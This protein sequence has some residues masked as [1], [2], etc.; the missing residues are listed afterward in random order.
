[1]LS[2][3]VKNKI[4][5]PE[6]N[7]QDDLRYIASRVFIP[8]LQQYID[9]QI[10]VNES[11]LP[12]IEPKTIA[13]KLRKGLSPKILTATGKLRSSL[14]SFDRGKRTVVISIAGDRKEIGGYLQIEGIK[15]RLGRKYFNFFGISS[16]MEKDA[17]SYM[18]AKIQKALKNG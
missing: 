7:F 8:R 11:P 15:T 16:R 14:Y 4:S 17:M 10:S 2:V 12:P 9:A 5:F 6:I 3:T 18:R 1:M 13:A